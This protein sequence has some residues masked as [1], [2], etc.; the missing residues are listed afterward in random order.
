MRNV[1][2]ATLFIFFNDIALAG[3]VLPEYSGAWYNTEQSGHGLSVE[4]ISS[5][6]ALVY[7]YA[8]DPEGHPIW[9]FIDGLID[10]D[11]IRGAAY[12]LD[13]MIWSEFDPDTTNMQDWG[14]VDIEFADCK[15]A[16]LDW[17]SLLPGYGSGQIQLY[18][19]TTIQGLSCLGLEMSGIYRGN[20]DSDSDSP[21]NANVSGIA[22]ISQDGEFNF[23]PD[24]SETW[25]SA[26][27]INAL[28]RPV[29]QGGQNEFAAKGSATIVLMGIPTPVG[30]EMKG[31]YGADEIDAEYVM[32]LV[33]FEVVD[34][35]N[36][37]LEKLTDLSNEALNLSDLAGDWQLED[38]QS[39]SE[40]RPVA[41]S[42]DGKFDVSNDIC[43][44]KI[45]M[46]VP[47]PDMSLLEFN[48]TRTNCSAGYPYYVDGSYTGHAIHTAAGTLR[49]EES[50]YLVVWVDPEGVV[51]GKPYPSAYRL[52]R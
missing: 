29:P 33:E 17:N 24:E 47:D 5:E 37:T 43:T 41:V 10:G 11:T 25:W 8:Y 6:R 38:F 28:I 4:V 23:I 36:L 46:T 40:S 15:N 21:W 12:Y 22:F 3:G 50:I 32:P 7:W 44:Q 9:L 42:A 1:L 35:G 26:R 16:S 27:Y 18:H 45:E 13:G 31:L 34:S 14:T 39:D 48:L 52:T 30:F 51:G 19:L 2:L 20:V 49:P